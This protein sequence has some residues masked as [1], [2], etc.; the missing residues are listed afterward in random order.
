MKSY[1]SKL[2]IGVKLPMSMIL[3]V[4]ATIALMAAS[5]AV[6]TR[7]LIAQSASDSLAVTAGIHA[8]RVAGL[9]EGIDRDLRLQTRSQNVSVALTA[10]IDGYEALDKPE[11]VLRRAYITENPNP[12]GEKDKLVSADTGSSYGF[13]HN[14]FHTDLHRLQQ[15]MGYYDVFLI[16]PDGNLVYSVFKEDDFATNLLTGQW[17][18]SGLAEVFRRAAE[19]GP[20]D[21]TAFVDF[22]PYAPSKGAPASFI[23]RPVFR[24]DGELLGVL[25][26]QMPITRL[27]EIV[28]KASEGDAVLDGFILN[29]QGLMLTDTPLTPVEDTLST[30]VDNEAVRKAIAGEIA[31]FDG[32]GYT[33]ASV[34]GSYVPIDFLG[35]RWIVGEQQDSTLVFAGMWGSLL[36]IAGISV[37]ILLAGFVFAIVVARGVSGPIQRL[38]TSVIK[39]ADGALAEDVPETE[40]GDEIGALARATE[41]FRQNSLNM[42]KLNRE[43]AAAQEKMEEMAKEQEVAAKRE[44]QAVSER[45]EA[46]LAATAAR[47][48]MMQDLGQSFGAVVQEAID[49]KFSARVVADFADQTLIE[50]AEN[51]NLLMGAVDTGLHETGTTLARVAKGDLNVQMTGSFKGDFAHLQGNV[52]EMITALRT[53]VGEISESGAT[54]SNSASELQD[55]SSVL[56]RQAEQNAASMEETSAALEELSASVKQVSGNMAEVSNDSKL[57]RDT[58]LNSETIAAEAAASME[59]I[60]DGSKE[61]AN[62][63]GTIN[64]IAF[65]IN[66]LALN[67]GVEAARAGEAG[68]GF[69]VVASEV[70]GLAQRASEAAKEIATVIERSD[71]AVAEGVS[72]V[73]GAKSSLEDIAARVVSISDNVDTVNMAIS[74]QS[75]GIADIT[76]T[77]VQID[78]NAQRQAAAFEELTA[79][80][81]LLA[82]EAKEL[83]K[84]TAQFEVSTDAGTGGR[85]IAAE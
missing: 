41:V 27:T 28:S 58:A 80:S 49:G 14:T 46:D 35:T 17:A 54:L 18:E 51:M 33:G 34:F 52:N 85:M 77:L 64:D 74:E 32:T 50:L 2:P 5:S 55:T 29:A 12:V 3:L 66:L 63:T 78:G 76:T 84:S 83:I 11:E 48:K 24:Q 43:Q 65:Q 9:I 42:E 15:E 73:A 1:F 22:A 70:R 13:I 23:A 47:E 16:D 7:N 39:V 82:G 30:A 57:A 8:Q 71:L 25:A 62:V 75:A 36:M 4:F 6:L 81:H 68:R 59:R 60:A 56:S 45:Q 20:T 31:T 40:R 19:L 61:I 67:A 69:S 53:L 37:A 10:F 26:F 79:S 21:P 44:L 72:K 38:T